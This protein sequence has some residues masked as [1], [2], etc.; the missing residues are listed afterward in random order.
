MSTLSCLD[1]QVSL[2]FHCLWLVSR[3]KGYLPF[4]KAELFA[5][6]ILP[7][8][9]HSLRTLK[10]QMKTVTSFG[11]IL[12]FMHLFWKK[13]I[14][15]CILLIVIYVFPSMRTLWKRENLF[16]WRITPL[17][18]RSFN[19]HIYLYRYTW[20][21]SLLSTKPETFFSSFLRKKV[22][23]ARFSHWSVSLTILK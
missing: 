7:A 13:V 1:A 3:N 9:W 12:I 2:S 23:S 15:L 14:S 21:R 17:L 10:T 6:K 19:L 16:Y 8:N 20:P 5:K 4:K 22:F 11:R 18:T